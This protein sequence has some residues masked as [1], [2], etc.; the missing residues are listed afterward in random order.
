MK[1]LMEYKII[2]GRT[3]ETRRSLISIGSS[4][5]KPRGT[6]KAGATS[7]AKIKANERECIRNLARVLNCNYE[8][9]D[10]FVTLKYD[11]EHYPNTEQAE[12]DEQFDVRDLAVEDMKRF[13]AKLRREYR[14]ETGH[15]LQAVWVSAN[16]SPYRQAPARLH[17]HMVV[18]ADALAAV[19]KVWPEFGGAGTIIARDL[20]NE[21]DYSK[22]AAYMVENVRTKKGKNK[23]S[24]SRGMERP[25]YTEPVEVID[26]EDMMPEAGAVIKDVSETV[27]EDGRVIGKYMRCALPARP[28]VRGGQIILPKRKR[29]RL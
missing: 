24:C 9:G 29:P 21:G 18:K 17:Q 19:R 25:I 11:G 5:K 10:V 13:L 28:K 22:L 2:S 15:T 7:E 12:Q 16:W 1:K 14:K 4:Y 3:V 8:A 20:N 23:W 27:D 6:R 26:T